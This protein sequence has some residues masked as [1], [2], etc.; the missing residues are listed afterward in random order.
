MPKLDL[1]YLI[2]NAL[3]IEASAIAGGR[4]RPAYR[5]NPNYFGQQQ[6]HVVHVPPSYKTSVLLVKGGP[7]SV[8]VLA[9][10][11]FPSSVHTCCVPNLAE[12][13]S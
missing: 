10:T 12:V 2:Q 13:P 7:A 4:E 5:R 11:S 9:S 6:I 8:Q 1:P 3:P